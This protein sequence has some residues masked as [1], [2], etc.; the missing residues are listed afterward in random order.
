MKLTDANFRDFVSN[1]DLKG[2]GIKEQPYEVV[3]FNISDKKLRII[4]FHSF[5]RFFQ[6]RLGIISMRECKNLEYHKMSLGE[7]RMSKCSNISLNDCKI[8]RLTMR[9]C[10]KVQVNNCEIKNLSLVFS[11]DNSFRNSVIDFATAYLSRYNTFKFSDVSLNST[12]EQCREKKVRPDIL[13]SFLPII[14]ISA[15][16]LRAP[17]LFFLPL[18]LF[19]G[20]F[21][22]AFWY[23]LTKILLKARKLAKYHPTEIIE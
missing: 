8:K 17:D 14:F 2:Y 4:K 21:V 22:F 6:G 20:L 16:L 10:Y 15:Y 23:N 9:D 3:E 19:L 13:L 1:Y 5:L 12:I 18:C 11:Y 7:L